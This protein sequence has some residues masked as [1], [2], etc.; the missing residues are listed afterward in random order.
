[1]T[2]AATHIQNNTVDIP[3]LAYHGN[4]IVREGGERQIPRDVKCVGHLG[5]SYPG[6]ANIREGKGRICLQV[7][8]NVHIM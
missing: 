1:V 7:D 3:T 8:K 4:M 6:V 5:N 2:S